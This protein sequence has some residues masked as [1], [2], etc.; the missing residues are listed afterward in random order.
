MKNYVTKETRV[1]DVSAWQEIYYS[2]WVTVYAAENI[3]GYYKVKNPKKTKY[4]K[5]E[6]A[7]SDIQ[8]YVYDL[9]DK[10]AYFIF[11]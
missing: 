6:M 5:G 8:R 11:N 1:S 10:G 3:S 9:G 4:F 7:W 2:P